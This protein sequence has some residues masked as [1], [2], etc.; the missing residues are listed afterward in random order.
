MGRPLLQGALCGLAAAVVALLLWLGGALAPLENLTWAWRAAWFARGEPRTPIVLIALDQGSLDWGARENGLSWPWPREAYVPILDFCRRAG[1][2]AVA[3]DLLFSEP[4]SYGVAD[5]QALATALSSV[6]SVVAVALS[7]Q[8]PP[9]GWPAG[10]KPPA[11]TG[12][13]LSTV[14]P[15]YASGAFPLRELGNAGRF[16]GNV[17]SRPDEDGIYRRLSLL[18]RLGAQPVPALPLALL[19]AA[20]PSLP[21]TVGP[22]SLNVGRHAAPTDAGGAA[23]LRFHGGAGTF[24]TLSAAAVIQSELRLRDGGAPGIDPAGLRGAYVIFGL[25]APGLFDLRATPLDGVFPG[26]EI[27][28]TALDNLLSG[29]FLRDVPRGLTVILTIV[30]AM[31]VGAVLRTATRIRPILVIGAIALP[32]PMLAG[33]AAYQG[34]WWLPVLP[35]TV[36]LAATFIALLLINYATE[37]K[38]RR[39]I[40]QAFNQYLHPAVIEQL[41]QHPGSLRLGGERR[42]I[43]VFFSD[44]QGFSTFSEQLEPEALTALLNEYLTAMTDIILDR[45]GTVD[46]YVGDAIVAFWNAPLDQPDHAVRAVEAALACQA[47]LAALRPLLRER[48]GYS[49]HMRIGINTGPAVVGNMGSQRRFDYTALG[50]TVNLASR[51][52]GVN[53]EFGSEILLAGATVRQLDGRPAVREVARVGVVGK[54][55]PVTIF[56]PLAGTVMSSEVLAVF[57]EALARYYAGEFAEAAARFALLGEGDPVARRHMGRC[58]E[59]IDNPPTGWDGV[60]WMTSK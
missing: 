20:E 19:L 41:L 52:E 53:K 28:A 13:N 56:E 39:Y 33:F 31:A 60:W 18:D 27:H 59:M 16:T 21:V 32:L 25:T 1:A 29:G 35:P 55:E 23:I 15:R 57:A 30:A 54:S 5:D 43:T 7:R 11:V 37:G 47:R 34:G 44:L 6:P 48:S 9:A 3:F 45:G 49:L 26:M 36:A 22:E 38:Q 42:E 8:D 46:K 24:P 12:R 14:V 17:S 50:D 10:L 40:R 58:R 2:R 51:L 4:S